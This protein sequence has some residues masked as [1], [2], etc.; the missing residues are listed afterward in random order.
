MKT[1]PDQSERNLTVI[2]PVVCVDDNW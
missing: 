2:D 1:F